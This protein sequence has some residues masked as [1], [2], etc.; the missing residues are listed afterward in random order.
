MTSQGQLLDSAQQTLSKRELEVRNHKEGC[1]AWSLV[2][3]ISRMVTLT[4]LLLSDLMNISFSL[5][6]SIL[7]GLF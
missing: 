7:T 2:A 5:F 4:L 1:C 3:T 6:V